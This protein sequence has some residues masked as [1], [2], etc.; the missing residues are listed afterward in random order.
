MKMSV[1][2]ANPEQMLLQEIEDKRCKRF[3]VAWTYALAI[4]SPF[5]KEVNWPKVNRAIIDRWSIHALRWIKNKAW[6]GKDFDTR[7]GNL[8]GF[9]LCEEAAG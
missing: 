1:V 8:E 5:G 3:D 9:E 4:R 2:L 7:V 6:S